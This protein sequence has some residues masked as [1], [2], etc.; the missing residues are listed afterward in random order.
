M[1]D[2]VHVNDTNDALFDHAY[3]CI[4]TFITPSMFDVVVR[5]DLPRELSMSFS[6]YSK[7]RTNEKT[8]RD[9]DDTDSLVHIVDQSI[10]IVYV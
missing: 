5:T 3:Q 7:E 8:Y 1:I 10:V 9:H 4:M 6:F 2:K